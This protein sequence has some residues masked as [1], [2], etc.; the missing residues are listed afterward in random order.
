MRPAHIHNHSSPQ[1]KFPP[2]R[3]A[4]ASLVAGLPVVIH[5]EQ[6]TATAYCGI[7]QVCGGGGRFPWC[8]VGATMRHGTKR[9]P[10]VANRTVVWA[11]A[12]GEACL[13]RDTVYYGMGATDGAQQGASSRRMQHPAFV[14]SVSMGY[15]MWVSGCTGG[16]LRRRAEVRTVSSQGGAGH[17]TSH[18]VAAS[19]PGPTVR[20]ATV[21]GAG[22]CARVQLQGAPAPAPPPPH[23]ARAR[24]QLAPATPGSARALSQ[25]LRGPPLPAAAPALPAA[26]VDWVLYS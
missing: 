4:L 10:G 20:C 25:L 24:A 14:W 17:H 18:C 9:V 3:Q 26:H 6:E 8:S 15:G 21:N 12:G 23:P 22:S 2:T 1:P 16:Q 19:V 11:F 5:S 7:L 13:C